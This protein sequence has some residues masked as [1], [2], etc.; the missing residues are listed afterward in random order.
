M[1]LL[2]ALLCSIGAGALIAIP[3]GLSVNAGLNPLI[4]GGPIAV[5]FLIGL[6]GTAWFIFFPTP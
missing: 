6:S 5:L 3:I 1:L 2:I 4:V